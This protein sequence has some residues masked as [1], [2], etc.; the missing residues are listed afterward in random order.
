MRSIPHI[1]IA[2]F[3]ALSI[4]LTG[5]W[6]GGNT[7]S[8]APSPAFGPSAPTMNTP[9]Y[10]PTGPVAPTGPTLEAP[11]LDGPTFP[12]SQNERV[13]PSDGFNRKRHSQKLPN[14]NAGSEYAGTEPPPFVLDGPV[15]K[16]KPKATD[17]TVGFIELPPAP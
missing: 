2:L 5:C 7:R 16:E 11:V 8:A 17:R 9:Q 6:M 15:A 4:L 10:G 14:G 1:A 12:Q 13:N 3:C